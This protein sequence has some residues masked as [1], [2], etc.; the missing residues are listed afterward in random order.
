MGA[1]LLAV[2]PGRVGAALAVDGLWHRS[3]LEA[4][5]QQ[6]AHAG[7]DRVGGRGEDR[8]ERVVAE[9]GAGWHLAGDGRPLVHSVQQGLLALWVEASEEL[10]QIQRAVP[11]SVLTARGKGS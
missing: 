2:D 9:L 1:H 4:A 6:D 7:S 3:E 10:W 5:A 11:E 8:D